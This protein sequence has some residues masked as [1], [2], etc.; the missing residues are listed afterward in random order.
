MIRKLSALQDAQNTAIKIEITPSGNLRYYDAEK[1]AIKPGQTRGASYVTEYVPNTGEVSSWIES[2][3]HTG[4][5]LRVHPKMLNGQPLNSPHY[6]QTASEILD[7][8]TD[9]PNIPRY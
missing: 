2:Y 7:V 1:P 6:P 5:I 9:S 4:T 3:D 8:F